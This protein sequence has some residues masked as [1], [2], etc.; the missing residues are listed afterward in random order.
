MKGIPTNWKKPKPLRAGRFGRTALMLG[1]AGATAGGML[2]GAGA[3]QA[4]V[5]DNPGAVAL[6]VPSGPTTGQPT[7]STTV[8]CAAG[9][10]GSAI[11]RGVNS[12]GGTYSIST[13]VNSVAT[14]FSGTLQG[15]IA[16]IQ[17][18]GGIANGATQELVVVCFSGASTQ[19]TSSPEMDIWITYSADGST[20]TTSN[21]PP[22][23]ADNTTTTPSGS[24]NPAAPG[25]NV[26]L[27]ATVTDTSHPGTIPVGSVQFSEG[28]TNV[29]AAVPVNSSGV[30]TL[31][32]PTTFAAT[33][34]VAVTAVFTPTSTT[35]FSTS[36]GTFN[37]VVATNS[38]SE[39][40][41]VTVPSSGTFSLTVATGTVNLAVSG[42]TATGSLNPV[43][44]SDTRNTFPGWSVSG[45]SADFLGSGTAATGDI[46]GNQLGWV[47]NDTS[48]GTG[49]TLG[50][51]VNPV[52]PGLGT[53]AAVLAQAHSGSGFGTSA[54]GAALTLD[55]PTTAP[56]GPYT[57]SLTLTAVTSL[58]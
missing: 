43:T 38:G 31:A 51:T 4:A 57:S 58:P 52:T 26:T 29:G 37:E 25:A 42:A 8:A 10:Q 53:T 20:Y 13:A 7:W 23:G 11:F 44:V 34:T 21:S 41:A 35:A 56:A 32:T 16:Q 55:I 33:G 3:A 17:S 47:P 50:G 40:L 48:L 15:T 46:S 14:P 27:S 45:Q 39:P 9:F 49:V 24:P 22:A 54:L 2:L 19:G 6:S 28:G 36:T 5:G 12:T 18:L 30:A 1:V